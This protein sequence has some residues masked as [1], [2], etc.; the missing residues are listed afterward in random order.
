[1]IVVKFA[2]RKSTASWKICCEWKDG[3]THWEMLTN[4]K[5]AY[6]A[7][8]AEHAVFEGIEH[9]TAFNW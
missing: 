3:S 2:I 1:M 8:V 9:K 6:L 4:L 7:Q 5:E